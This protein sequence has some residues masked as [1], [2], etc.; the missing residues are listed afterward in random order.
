MANVFRFR[1]GNLIWSQGSVEIQISRG[2]EFLDAPVEIILQELDLELV[3]ETRDVR[4]R[5]VRA[6]D[7]EQLRADIAAERW[8]EIGK[9]QAQAVRQQG[10]AYFVEP[11][12]ITRVLPDS[13]PQQPI[14]FKLIVPTGAGRIRREFTF[15]ITGAAESRYEVAVLIKDGSGTQL[16]P[17]ANQFM[18]FCVQGRVVMPR[19]LEIVQP[20]F[21]SDWSPP[22][23]ESR[24][25]AEGESDETLAQN[26]IEAIT[27]QLSGSNIQRF[28]NGMSPYTSA[29]PRREEWV[30]L[31]VE[32]MTG[33]PYK[34][35]HQAYGG[36][37]T[38]GDETTNWRDRVIS[39]GDYPCSNVCDQLASMIQY[40]RGLPHSGSPRD[41][42]RGGLGLHAQKYR[43]WAADTALAGQGAVYYDNIAEARS[44]VT[45]WA[46]PGASIF[47]KKIEWDGS[48]WVLRTTQDRSGIGHENTIMRTRDGSRGQEVQLFDYGGNI[49]GP[50]PARGYVGTLPPVA[51]ES[52]WIPA[53][54]A[55]TLLDQS[56][57]P[58]R[59]I[60]ASPPKFHAV[61][62]CPTAE[63]SPRR[64][65]R[66]L[67][68]ATLTVLR[69]GREIGSQTHEE[70][71]GDSFRQTILPV[72][73]YLRALSGLPH[74]DVTQA[75]IRI[76]S[77]PVFTTTGSPV[78]DLLE[79]TTDPEGFVKIESLV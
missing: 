27:R 53:V 35:G 31:A 51:Q 2:W 1:G 36:R 44:N 37:A 14:P 71:H 61:G 16:A 45:A 58:A 39:S 30:R 70:L 64:L 9:V 41:Y 43:A 21:R 78:L 22:S 62:W 46:K 79:I 18:L 49:G 4:Q 15:W 7:T 52:G 55:L 48:E 28:L 68:E 63:T 32:H 54:N 69:D 65:S 60:T 8:N 56:P 47:Y 67:G 38:G 66:P 5:L 42:F 59:G 26:T 10:N 74:S 57:I 34:Q 23:E 73:H 72:T 13:E 50:G 76:R 33:L 25:V 19:Y 11:E 17:S 29:E 12:G 24:A 3:E 77:R 6:G 40:I 20:Y 75:K